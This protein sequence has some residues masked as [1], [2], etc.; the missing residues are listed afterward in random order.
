[1]RRVAVVT[2]GASGIGL[3]ISRHLSAAG[4]RVAVL[5]IDAE[6]AARTVEELNT[7]GSDAVSAQ[8]DVSDRTAVEAAVDEVRRRFGAVEIMVT[9]AA[10]TAFAPFL[11]ISISDWDRIVAVD[12]TGTFHCLQVVLPDMIA[13]QWGRIVTISSSAGQIGSP[14]QGHYAAAKGGVIAMT[15]TVAREYARQGI[16]ANTIPP[17]IVDTPMARDAQ[18]AGTRRATRPC[19]A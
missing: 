11:D 10:V 9:S 19:R 14:R 16:T 8:V 3:G 15:K 17:F 13:G 5:D 18:M 7:A 1:M 6:A 2:G 12:L 4:H